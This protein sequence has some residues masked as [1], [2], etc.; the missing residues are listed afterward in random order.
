MEMAEFAEV[1]LPEF[2]VNKNAQP[3]SGDHEVHDLSS[4]QGCLPDPANRLNLGTYTSCRGAVNAA[5]QYYDDV[6]GCYY[7]ANECHTT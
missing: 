1:T 6:N 3:G 4:Q 7:C 5:K 2:C